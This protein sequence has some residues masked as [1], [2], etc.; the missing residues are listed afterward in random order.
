[1]VTMNNEKLIGIVGGVGPYAGLDLIRKIFDQTEAKS[2]QE[3]LPVALLS[4]P[5]EVEDR[6]AF[7]SGHTTNNPA[8]GIVKVI[9]KLVAIGASV[10]GI[11]CNTAHAPQIFNVIVEEINKANIS[12]KLV[13]MIDEVSKFIRENHADIKNIGI[14]GTMGT[15]KTRIYEMVLKGENINVIVPDERFQKNVHDAI[16]DHEFGIKAQSNPVTETAKSKLKEAI[17]HLHDKGAEAIVLGCT[18]IPLAITENKINDI[19][20]IDPTLILA[21]ALIREVSPD[22]LK[23]LSNR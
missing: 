17:A 2:D 7:L 3:H 22:K 12:V 4:L 9:K 14:I 10:V 20:I 23:H 18:E 11:A 5:Q 19:V 1:M 16:Y 8:Y 13:N 21:R 6:T 15:F